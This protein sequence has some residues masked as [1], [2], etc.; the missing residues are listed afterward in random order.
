MFSQTLIAIVRWVCHV[1]PSCVA[2]EESEKTTLSEAQATH[3]IERMEDILKQLPEV[4]RVANERIIGER[5]VPSN[6]KIIS[7]FETP[8]GNHTKYRG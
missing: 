4:K 6:E 7:P 3:I 5:K 2:C 1:K 8:Y